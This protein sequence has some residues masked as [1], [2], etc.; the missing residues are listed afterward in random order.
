MQSRNIR[1]RPIMAC[2]AAA[3]TKTSPRN[4]HFSSPHKAATGLWRVRH[5]RKE[6]RT[7][8]LCAC[9]S[10]P[11]QLPKIPLSPQL[12][13]DEPVCGS[14][15]LRSLTGVPK[16]GP[17]VYTWLP[18]NTQERFSWRVNPALRL[19]P[20]LPRSRDVPRRSKL[21]NPIW[22]SRNSHLRAS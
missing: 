17:Q 11:P 9:A 21:F 7:L 10:L 16:I 8:Q 4:S 13:R 18:H 6:I 5:S 1:S 2:T 14:S 22:F 3:T 19:P 15:A 20:V 12:A